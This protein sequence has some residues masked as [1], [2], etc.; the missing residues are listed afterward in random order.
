M[1]KR[2]LFVD[3]DPNILSGLRRK[4]RRMRHEWDMDFVCDGKEALGKMADALYDVVVSDYMMPGMN[5]VELLSIIRERFPD[6]IRII[7][8]GQFERESIIRFMGS[9]HRY[10]AKPCGA[11]K[12]M[13]TIR[14][15]D[16]LRDMVANDVVGRIFSQIDS[17]PSLPAV[18]KELTMELLCE[19]ASAK[20]IEEIL[21]RDVGTSARILQ[22]VNSAY[23]GLP[24]HVGSLVEAVNLLGIETIMGLVLFSN[25]FSQFNQEKVEAFSIDG[26]MAHS[27]GTG[28][29]AK[30]IASEE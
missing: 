16:I 29:L 27:G 24:R 13:S 3:D 5:G 23:F 14:N 15:A 4:L 25:L 10:L 12:L 19:G 28:R 8:S 30:A 21:S 22:L 11:E 1:K 6:C 26:L 20:R 2:I 17:L 7:L 9:A 18:Y